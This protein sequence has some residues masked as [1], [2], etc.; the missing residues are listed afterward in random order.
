MMRE[1]NYKKLAAEI[2]IWIKNYINSANAKGVVLGLSGGID[3]AVTAA[4]CANA[5]GK[6]NVLGLGL[7]IESIPQDLED[8]KLVANNLG[9]SFAISDLTS[10]YR[11][12]VKVLPSDIQA[13]QMALANI[14]PRLRMTTVYY[15]G[16]SLGYLVGGTGNRAEIAIGYFTK[17][18]DGAADFEPL[19]SLYKC[20]VR[21]I[22]RILKIPERIVDKAPNAG[23]WPDQTDEG[24]IGM[25][26][27]L[28]DEILYRIDYFLELDDIAA[29]NVEKV[30]S[31]MKSAEHKNKMPPFFILILL[32]NTINRG[33]LF[34]GA[35]Y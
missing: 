25:T 19:A 9:I 2:E 15:V 13:N 21:E 24:E 10:V 1:L 6:E 12:L 27:P 35:S 33:H 3:S 32:T 14:K 4:L 23:L 18:G 7:P 26:Y 20:E 30:I 34:G 5:L 29:E 17:Y 28:L 22:A 16:Q 8:A 11:E 31:M